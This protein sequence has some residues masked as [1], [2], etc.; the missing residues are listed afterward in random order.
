[1]G[2]IEDVE[3]AAV[4][5]IARE[6]AQA[7]AVEHDAVA[8]Q[9]Q[10]EIVA[11]AFGAGGRALEQQWIARR[12]ARGHCEQVRGAGQAPRVDG[13]AGGGGHGGRGQSRRNT[14]VALVPPKPKPLETATSTRASRAVFGT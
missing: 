1:M 8:R 2:A 9:R 11:R 14:R 3:K 6:R 5:G 4:Q 13:G 7:G 12:P 10:Q